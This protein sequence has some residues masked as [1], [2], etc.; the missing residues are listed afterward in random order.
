[1]ASVID[2]RKSPSQQMAVVQGI[3]GGISDMLNAYRSRKM[4]QR[5]IGVLNDPNTKAEDKRKILLRDADF[6]RSP[7]GQQMM[8]QELDIERR[9]QM[10]WQMQY[11]QARLENIEAATRATSARAQYY[12]Q[13]AAR[14]SADPTIR[15]RRL[16]EIKNQANI[17]GDADMEAWADS[18]L[19]K[20][21]PLKEPQEQPPAVRQPTWPFPEDKEQT[22]AAIRVQNAKMAAP[23]ATQSQIVSAKFGVLPEGTGIGKQNIRPQPAVSRPE[24]AEVW[25]K[26]TDEQKYKVRLAM[27]RKATLEQI[28]EALALEGIQ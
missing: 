27:D 8:A 24:L 14:A 28:L 21:M 23:T 6:L 20:Y 11:N 4:Q 9:M 7:I 16:Q 26:L 1:M 22:A 3:G 10:Q 25:P 17:D 18:E 13:G 5:L 15:M 2:L 12:E 19:K